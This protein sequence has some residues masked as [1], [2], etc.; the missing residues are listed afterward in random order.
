MV[1][2]GR[3]CDV[4]NGIRESGGGAMSARKEQ[5]ATSLAARKKSSASQYYAEETESADYK[6]DEGVKRHFVS[7]RERTQ[8]RLGQCSLRLRPH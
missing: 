8:F 3:R 2:L 6:P 4:L 1:G 7:F 5:G